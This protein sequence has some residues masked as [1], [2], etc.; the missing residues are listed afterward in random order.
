MLIHQGEA[1]SSKADRHLA[2]SLAGVAGALNAAGFYA[3]A[4]YSANMTGNVSAL[5]DHLGMRNLTSA[6]PYL[7]LVM[8]FISGAMISTL[9]VNAGRRR[10]LA[11]IYA[12]ASSLRRFCWPALGARI[13]GCWPWSAAPAWQWD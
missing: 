5:A 9:L 1:R 4:L 8:T 11:G 6:A 3:V 13:C 2:W 10:G 7:A 12:V